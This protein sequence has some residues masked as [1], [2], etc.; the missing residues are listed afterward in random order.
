MS[1]TKA[2]RWAAVPA[3]EL[4]QLMPPPVCCRRM[5][6]SRSPWI[7]IDPILW[8]ECVGAYRNIRLA[9]L[10]CLALLFGNSRAVIA[11]QPSDAA[12]HIADDQ[13][14]CIS[15]KEC[16]PRL[17]LVGRSV[18]LISVADAPPQRVELDA[19][20]G[21]NPFL[22]LQ[23]AHGPPAFPPHSLDLQRFDLLFLTASR[24]NHRRS[25][26]PSPFLPRSSIATIDCDPAHSA[27]QNVR[28]PVIRFASFPPFFL[29]LSIPE[30]FPF[31]EL[32]VSGS[33]ASVRFRM[34]Q[35][36]LQGDPS[37]VCC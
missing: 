15:A 31:S 2:K 8:T 9:L 30:H 18:Q 13:R 3:R 1:Y 33:G 29:P 5:G 23:R 32:A 11:A 24:P 19:P 34:S 37:Y 4:P 36:H 26:S 27:I 20:R 6:V 22:D 35:N 28:L 14:R 10:A 16:S 25:P 12:V 21:D 17:R 7:S